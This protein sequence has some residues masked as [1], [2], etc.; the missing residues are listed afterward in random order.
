MNPIDA[1]LEDHA[2]RVLDGFEFG[3]G[4]FLSTGLAVPVALATAAG[5]GC[6]TTFMLLRS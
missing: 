5:L 2:W 4:F 3:F 1:A 6:L